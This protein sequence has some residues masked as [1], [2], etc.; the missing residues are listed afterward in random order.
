MTILWDR[1]ACSILRMWSKTRVAP[2]YLYHIAETVGPKLNPGSTRR[3]TLPNGAQMV[4]EVC[5]HVDRH[6]Y[7][8]GA[9][10]PIECYLLSKLLSPG[11][12]FFDLGANIGQYSLLASTWVAAEGA[13]H[14]FEPAERNLAR[15]RMHLALNRATNVTVNSC[16]VWSCRTELGIEW[17]ESDQLNS[18]TS[19]VRPGEGIP[20]V[21]LDDY[22]S[23]RGISRLDVIKMDI[24]G[25]EAQA[26][27]GGLRT[28]ERFRPILLMEVNPPAI[29]RNGASVAQIWSTL[30]RLGYEAF[31]IGQ[32]AEQSRS[33]ALSDELP[34]GN[35]IFHAAPLPL[36]ITR[37]WG[38]KQALAWAQ[39]AGKARASVFGGPVAAC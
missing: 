29:E 11:M 10:E 34:A 35:V 12:V 7:L 8:Y 30:R 14:A 25:S 33:V 9:Y 26:L 16:A 2:G 39:R 24:E 1:I 15:L 36:A 18:G 20:A 38:L 21:T 6:I 31:W 5:D 32:S 28:I 19:F 37:G 22:C 23:D 3:S 17:P 13:V 27:N 4:C